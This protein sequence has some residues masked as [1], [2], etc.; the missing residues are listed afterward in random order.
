MRKNFILLKKCF[1]SASDN[2]F[3]LMRNALCNK[4]NW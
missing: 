2:E 4:T 3:L 1:I